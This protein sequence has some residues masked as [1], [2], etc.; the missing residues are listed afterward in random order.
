MEKHPEPGAPRLANVPPMIGGQM[1]CLYR[2]YD[3]G[4]LVVT[5]RLTLE[6]LPAVG[7]QVPLNGR[8]YTVRAVEYDAGEPVLKL[9]PST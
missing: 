9:E 6:G 7:D 3:R 8:P 4:K 2:A 1:T 5:G